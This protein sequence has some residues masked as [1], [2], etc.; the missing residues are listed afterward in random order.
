MK[1]PLIVVKKKKMDLLF[2][3]FN[4]NDSKYIFCVEDFEILK[5]NKEEKITKVLDEIKK[6][7]YRVKTTKYKKL[8]IDSIRNIKITTIGIDLVNGCNLNCSYCFI[9]AAS[10]K[11]RKLKKNIFID[12]LKFIEK[13][14]E[15][16]I[17]FYFAGSGEPTLNFKL[18]KQLPSICLEYGFNNCFFDL[19]TNG[20]ILTNEMI[21]FF[22]QNKFTLNISLDGNKQINDQVRIY[23]N[24]LGSFND[25]YKN[26]KKLK[27]NKIDFVCKTVILPDNK[28]LVDVFSFFEKNKINFF[29]TIATNS[30]DN[31]FIPNINDL[32][33]FKKQFEII[34]QNYSK[35]IKNNKKI[36]SGKIINDIKR[37]HYGNANKIACEG[38]RG[39]FFIDIDGDIYTCSYHN[40]SKELSVGNI[41]TGINYDKIIN[42]NWYAKSVDDY[43]VCNNCWMKYLCS[44]SCFAIKWLENKNTN[45]P[46]EYLC[47]TYDIYWSSII[48]LY[49]QIYSEIVSGNN[50]NFIE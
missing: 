44:G 16:P 23:H 32:E 20:T 3:E 35:L 26:I 40:S 50:I 29:F 17:I 9:S 42:N 2:K 47:K 4:V 34:I 31:H 39:S 36:Y 41:Y 25:V 13:E 49:I 22:K 12:I 5:I 24:G 38:A 14:K 46:S 18:I 30:F 43:P 21:N 15:H 10:K 1:Q 7:K 48:K 27:E 37:I 8:E 6:E 33:N 19:T 11:K 45:E 28:N